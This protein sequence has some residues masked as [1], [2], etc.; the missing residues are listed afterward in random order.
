MNEILPSTTITRVCAL[1]DAA[2]AKMDE[3]ADL[4]VRGHAMA[5]FYMTDPQE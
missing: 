1:R 4:I 3:A 5:T 2:I